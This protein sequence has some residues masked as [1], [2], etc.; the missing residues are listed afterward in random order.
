MDLVENNSGGLTTRV[1]ACAR[2]RVRDRQR[3]LEKVCGSVHLGPACSCWTVLAAL[4]S[5]AMPKRHG[6]K[7]TVGATEDGRGVA[8]ALAGML[9]F[10]TAL[11]VDQLPAGMASVGQVPS[12]QAMPAKSHAAKVKQYALYGCTRP[13]PTAVVMYMHMH[14]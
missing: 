5:S 10:P 8:V 3:P 9:Y 14:M 4:V 11:I 2:D 6:A 7:A 12:L 13:V 1:V